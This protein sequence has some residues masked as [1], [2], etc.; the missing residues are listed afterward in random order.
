M[1]PTGTHQ[2]GLVVGR[3]WCR[4]VMVRGATLAVGFAGGRGCSLLAGPGGMCGSH[5]VWSHGPP[6]GVGIVCGYDMYMYVVCA[7]VRLCR[8]RHDRWWS[9]CVLYGVRQSEGGRLKRGI[10]LLR[11][12]RKLCGCLTLSSRMVSVPPS[13]GL[14]NAP[15]RGEFGAL[16]LTC[17]HPGFEG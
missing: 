10:Q 8:V 11:P 13:H 4:C 1:G 12:C 7:A 3:A 9:S 15:L 17:V 2:D 6:G 5:R 16:R 14:L